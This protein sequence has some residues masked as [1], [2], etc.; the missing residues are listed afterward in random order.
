MVYDVD[1]MSLGIIPKV[2]TVASPFAAREMAQA[3]THRPR[4]DID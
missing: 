3:I 4:A 1:P 2:S